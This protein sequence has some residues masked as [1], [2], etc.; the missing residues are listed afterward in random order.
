MITRVRFYSIATYGRI[1]MV[2][3]I[4]KQA[5][6]LGRIVSMTTINSGKDE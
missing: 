6:Q 1:G 5:E 3:A 2:T 4:E